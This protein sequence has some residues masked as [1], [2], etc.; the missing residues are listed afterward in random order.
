MSRSDVFAV[1]KT[2]DAVV[3]AVENSFKDNLYN[4]GTGKDLTIKSLAEMIQKIT[5]HTGEIEWDSEK[6]DGTP[7]ND[8]VV[9][10]KVLPA[11]A[12]KGKDISRTITGLW[13]R[14]FRNRG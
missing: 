8:P 9:N 7:F 3:F 11:G 12:Q 2:A 5:G 6:P 13:Q 1:T 14:F 4:V 10:V